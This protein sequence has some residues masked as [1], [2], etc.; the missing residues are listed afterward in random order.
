VAFLPGNRG[1]E[2]IADIVFGEYNPSGKL[3]ITY[4]RNVNGQ[5]NYDLRPIDEFEH[6]KKQ[7][8]FPFGHGLS[9]TKFAY[10]D[11]KLSPDSV[12]YDSAV[13]V[14]VMVKNTGKRDGQEVVILYLNDNVATISR[15]LKQVRLYF[16]N[17]EYS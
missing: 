2:A 4:P 6:N 9:Y 5:T 16:N 7:E 13:E 15:P 17:L 12:D 8:L 1:G 3:P 10:S 11:L 14:S